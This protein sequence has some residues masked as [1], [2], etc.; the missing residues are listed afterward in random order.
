MFLRTPAARISI[1]LVLLTVSILL[2][3]D[4]IGLAP[5]RSDAVLES[6][7]NLS[8][9]LAIQFST[10]ADRGDFPLI[11]GTLQAIVE[12]DSD[13]LSA[14]LRTK[15]GELL[16][17]AGDHLA[18]WES[19]EDNKS[20]STHVQVPIYK[21]K[22]HWANV[23]IRFAPLWVNDFLSGFK[24]SFIGLVLFVALSGF[25]GYFILMKRT[26]RELDPSE[27]IPE[28]VGAAF[29]VLEEGVLILD[30]KEYVVLANKSIAKILG[31]TS[32]KLIGYKGSELGW[33]GCKSEKQRKQLPWIQVIKT[34]KSQIG[35]PLTL[36]S[37]SSGS[38]KLMVNAAP[39]LD[40]KGKSRGVLTTFS[41]I[42]ELE[43]KN[44][45]LSNM[46][47]QLK[48]STEAIQNQNL[49]LEFLATHDPLTLCLN[50]RSLNKQ[51]DN[52]FTEAQGKGTE[53][54]AIMVDIDHFKSVNDRYGHSTG[55]KVIKT[56]AALLKSNSRDSD[57]VG[58]YGGE[59]F[60]LV[61]PG[62]SIEEANEIAERIRLAIKKDAS[63]GI[64]VT[65]S[66][67]VSSLKFNAH[68]PGEL[69]NQADKALY[70]AKESGRNH[71]V[72]W[73][74]DDV[75]TD[76]M[77]NDSVKSADS[78]IA[79]NELSDNGLVSPVLNDTDEVQRLTVRINQLEELAE[80]RTKELQHFIAYD[81][82][83]G[84]PTKT[85]FH[86]RIEQA[87][88]R[89]NRYDSI[90]AV[91]VLSVGAVKRINEIFGHSYGELFLKESAKRL[92]EA[93]RKIDTVAMVDSSITAPTVSMLGSEEFAI[94][95]T[96]LQQVDH[97]TW[98]VKRILDSFDNSFNI[99]GND[100]YAT[101]H[102]G[103]SVYPHDG[104]SAETLQKNAFA[105]NNYARKQTSGNRYR[106]HSQ[107]INKTAIKHLKIEAELR[108]ALK[109]EE[110]L[111]HYQP[112]IDAASGSII[113]VEAL[114]RWNSPVLGFVP[115]YDFI[116][117]AENSGLIL[118]IGD[119]V[120]STACMQAREWL[121]S[122][123]ECPIA[124]NFSPRQLRQANLVTR[125][126]ELLDE[127]QLTPRFIEMEITENSMM[128]NIDESITLLRQVDQMGMAIAIDDFGTGYSS[129]GY[130]K[131]LPATYVKIDRSFV[132][133][134]NT[135]DN[136]ASLVASII[137]MAHGLGVSVV[138]EGVE[139]ESQI[140]L[141]KEYGCDQLQGYFFSRPVPAVEATKLLEAGIPYTSPLLNA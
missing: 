53:L 38:V 122:G 100:I 112:K 134:I 93:L 60:C 20:T 18:Q 107:D 52:L 43:E 111:L 55:D 132:A 26:L 84:L 62:I 46:V 128:S 63:S 97:I 136:D 39:V 14:A 61:C 114:I 33:K 30:E 71:V 58:R 22:S 115:P 131:N 87:L 108:S 79:D 130:L 83:T 105:A 31:K 135:D 13:I 120:L 32:S 36:E 91:L 101:T 34:G 65:A 9:A 45:Q 23:E 17:L 70:I 96:D 51:F 82:Q 49:E 98:I 47:D 80:K 88:T 24:N 74:K 126:E 73:G 116:D 86:D 133:D 140:G 27:V 42:S 102:V 103:I 94:L 54:S 16:A 1:G 92:T 15:D 68:D 75:L 28:R 10:A 110:F 48:V 99:N 121:D 139:E 127:Y 44:F 3:A 11:R 64:S 21:A 125:I 124:V 19:P 90:V 2:V 77:A 138:A 29:D 85:L 78:V 35:I 106:F 69:I 129:L 109:N 66:F 123:I 119:W 137:N 81:A 41:D 67:G 117:I 57:L 141:L 113:A 4:L 6:R 118:P 7:K 8:E 25:A 5:D 40:S 89:S 50:R 12:R 104:E 37:H 59:E 76:T 95:L 72:C 56:I